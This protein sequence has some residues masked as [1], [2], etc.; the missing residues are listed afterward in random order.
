M[1]HN[2]AVAK[3]IGS[4]KHA[5]PAKEVP[6]YRKSIKLY[7]WAGTEKDAIKWMVITADLGISHQFVQSQWLK[8][9]MVKKASGQL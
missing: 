2:S 1:M 9:N 4:L 7:W 3:K 8:L 5:I 6:I